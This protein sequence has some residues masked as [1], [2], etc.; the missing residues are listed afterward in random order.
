MSGDILRMLFDQLLLIE[1][2]VLAILLSIMLLRERYLLNRHRREIGAEPS[3]EP[4]PPPVNFASV[5]HLR[6]VH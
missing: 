6:R 5:R 3:Q 4:A 1:G 2:L